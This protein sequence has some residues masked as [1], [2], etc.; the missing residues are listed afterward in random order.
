MTELTARERR[1]QR[2]KDAILEAARQIIRESGYDALSMRLIAQRIDY[3]PAGLYEYFGSKEE[4]VTAVC[5][6][7]MS[8]FSS[9][10]AAVDI[11]L[12]PA[13][14]IV[15]LG[16]AYIH[17]ALQNKERFLLMFTTGLP[18]AEILAELDDESSYAILVNGI[19]RG[20]DAGVFLTTAEATAAEMAYT[21]WALVHGISMLRL[22]HLP[23]NAM[24]F[25]AVDRA[26][27]EI[28]IKGLMTG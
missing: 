24:N 21:A 15:E 7:T 5:R 18:P 3:S 20:I 4:I 22:S 28:F 25:E 16:L 23:E 1:H 19:Q 14:Y 13:A 10:L 17:Y 11:T 27:L 26:A 8:Q 2:T 9:S 12:P 6:Q